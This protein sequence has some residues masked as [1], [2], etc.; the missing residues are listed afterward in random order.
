M[1]LKFILTLLMSFL[2]IINGIA[3]KGI[4]GMINAELSFAKNAIEKDTKTAFLNYLDSNG[5]VFNKGEIQDGIKTWSA[6]QASAK[7]KL[8]WHPI[9]AGM[10]AS[11]DLGFTTGPWIFKIT[12]SD[13]IVASGFFS[14]I[15]HKTKGGQW[16][17]LADMGIDCGPDLYNK[18]EIKKWVSPKPANNSA[19][20]LM[21]EKNFITAY[22]KNG[23]E[24]FKEYID[25]NSW[26]SI[27]GSLPFTN[28]KDILSNALP[29]IPAGLKFTP[30]KAE[31]AASK[32]LGYVYGYVELG[33][34][35][36]N[37]MRVWK[38][39]K[40]GGKILLQVLRR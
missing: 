19:D 28:K 33:N 1:N 23:A 14:T 9:Y 38:I 36:E 31:M 35:K 13:T 29:K 24:A 37:Y 40:S 12:G 15:W 18:A 26:F 25:D 10:A 39:D 22:E 6:R 34:K 21:I 27:S 16:K 4:D 8:Y 7:N 3:Q 17:F 2:I 30:V 11:G 32:E 20:I 5:V